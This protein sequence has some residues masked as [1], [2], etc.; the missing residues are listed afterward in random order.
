MYLSKPIDLYDTETRSPC[1]Y[2]GLYNKAS[3]DIGSAIVT[4]STTLMQ[5]IGNRGNCVPELGSGEQGW[6]K[7]HTVILFFEFSFQFF[8][9]PKTALKI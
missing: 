1:I 4:K 8:C 2:Y 5:D 9:T 7:G 6:Q 3:L